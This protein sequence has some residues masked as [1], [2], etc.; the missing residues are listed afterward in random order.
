M[1]TKEMA[2]AGSHDARC[3]CEARQG[4]GGEAHSS[5]RYDIFKCGFAYVDGAE[6]GME[7]PGDQQISVLSRPL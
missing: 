3:R 6:F 5:C 2:Q 4:R 1:A 7:K